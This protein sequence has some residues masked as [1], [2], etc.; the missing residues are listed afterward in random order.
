MQANSRRPN[1]SSFTWPFESGNCSKVGQNL[2]KIEYFDKEKGFLDEINEY[3]NDRRQKLSQCIIHN[4]KM[5]AFWK[6]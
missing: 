3:I 6:I 2:Q 5:S 4:T 1:Y